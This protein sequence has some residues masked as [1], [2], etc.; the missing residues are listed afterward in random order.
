MGKDL[1]AASGWFRQHE[2]QVDDLL[3][4]SVRQ[5]CLENPGN[6]L[7]D[8][9]FTQPA[10]YIVNALQGFEAIIAG[11]RPD[12]L[13]GHSLGEYNA[14][15]SA[16]AFDVFTGLKLVQGRGELMAA[17]AGGRMAAI[18]GLTA[19]TVLQVLQDCGFD[20]LNIANINSPSQIVISGDGGQVLAAESAFRARGATF[21]HPLAVNAAFH[22][23]QMREAQEAFAKFL[24]AFEFQTPH[25]PVISNATARPYPFVDASAQIP[26]RLAQQISSPVRWM[27]SIR[28]LHCQGVTD[29]QELG[30]GKVLTRLISEMIPPAKVG[31][32]AI[33][34][35]RRADASSSDPAQTRRRV[36]I[37]ARDNA[38]TGG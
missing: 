2:P 11:D 38:P 23:G 14:L 35:A 26:R 13:A 37:A 4:F 29:F 1:F 12:F 17:A 36:N 9:R 31:R 3:G 7:L 32:Q 27:D 22:S 21:Y 16:G 10:V 25:T 18:V 24:E 6:R 5:L 19:E 33:G 20:N 15:L 8:T 34:T 30:P 28:Y